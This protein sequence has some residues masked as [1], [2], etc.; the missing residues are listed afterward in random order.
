VAEQKITKNIS[1][2]I[3]N[4]YFSKQIC[5]KNLEILKPI[6]VECKFLKE[7]LFCEWRRGMGKLVFH[8]MLLCSK[9]GKNVEFKMLNLILTRQWKTDA[10][11]T[12]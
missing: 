2:E 7:K 5:K 6:L 3:K 8:V 11:C 9:T 4:T 1:I 10:M 12:K